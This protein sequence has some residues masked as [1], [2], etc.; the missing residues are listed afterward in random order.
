[1]AKRGKR[2][3]KKGQPFDFNATEPNNNVNE[4][5]QKIDGAAAQ[6]ATAEDGENKVLHYHSFDRDSLVY[7]GVPVASHP[8]QANTTVDNENNSTDTESKETAPGDP[9]TEPPKDESTPIDAS[10]IPEQAAGHIETVPDEQPS[11][12]PVTATDSPSSEDGTASE[13]T[14][15]T[16]PT[17]E[18][19][20]V[21]AVEGQIAENDIKDLSK[22]P[23]ET[24]DG[25]NPICPE[26]SDNLETVESSGTEPSSNDG[27]EV[28]EPEVPTKAANEEEQRE[29]ESTFPDVDPAAEIDQVE[30]EKEAEKNEAVIDDFDFEASHGNV[31]EAPDLE[32][33]KLTY[34][35]DEAVSE[36]AA[37]ESL[38]PADNEHDVTEE[39]QADS[40]SD[41]NCTTAKTAVDDDPKE[42]SGIDDTLDDWTEWEDKPAEGLKE[43]PALGENASDTKDDTEESSSREA[44]EEAVVGAE[45]GKVVAEDDVQEIDLAGKAEENTMETPTE[46]KELNIDVEK[47]GSDE[48]E[49]TVVEPPPEDLTAAQPG[50][51]IDDD[52][53]GE[54]KQEPE[55]VSE[56][57]IE[58][59]PAEVVLE[60]E[61]NET[62]T[63]ATV[64]TETPLEKCQPEE[65]LLEPPTKEASVEG[66]VTEKIPAEETLVQEAPV[67]EGAVEEASVEETPVKEAPVEEASV[68]EAPVEETSVKESVVEE[69]SVKESVVE[70][71]PVKET[72]VKEASVGKTPVEKTPVEEN[73]VEEISVKDAAVEEASVKEAS[74]E[75]A[76]VKET[77]VK[78]TPVEEA[79]VEEASVKETPVKEAP[80]EETS[81]KEASVEEASVKETSVKETSV[82]EASV[83]ETSVEEIS[84]KESAV[85]ET[86]VKETPVK[87]ASVKETSVKK[88]SVKETSVKESAVE[89]ASVEE[90]VV[91]E[92][93]VK[94][95]PV[96]EAPVEEA[97]VKEA[98]VKE[99]S[100]EEGAVEEVPVKDAA[101]E[102]VLVPADTATPKLA[103]DKTIAVASPNVESVRSHRRELPEDTR[104][105]RHKQ[106]ERHDNATSFEHPPGFQ[107]SRG[108]KEEYRNVGPNNLTAN[109]LRKAAKMYADQEQEEKRRR[110]RHR[111]EERAPTKYHEVRRESASRSRG[112]SSQNSLSSLAAKPVALLKLLANGESNTSGP[113]LRVN[114]SSSGPSKSPARH[115][116][117]SNRSHSHSHGHH[118]HRRHH[119]DR[120]PGVGNERRRRRELLGEV[121]RTHR[122]HREHKEHHKSRRDSDAQPRSARRDS[123]THHEDRERRG[124]RRHSRR[125]VEDEAPTG[126]RLRDRIKE[127]LRG[128]IPAAA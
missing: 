94:E 99:A 54:E 91:E 21:L 111:E 112:S 24:V 11:K 37:G 76:S 102:E 42:M 5:S 28:Q 40:E 45:S 122:E 36:S 96:K 126:M 41:P 8:P 68:E 15:D 78:E 26:A 10:D 43:L 60:K 100:V 117:S 83:E 23:D 90:N 95:A 79:S 73:V 67:E 2:K 116:D 125:Y 53:L 65:S 39:P 74:V 66:A 9:P 48:P 119:R 88:T 77:S 32:D 87:E 80:V 1:M 84:V 58:D 120:S 92:A 13:N 118:R 89:E 34:T 29:D 81:V 128:I 27:E 57:I 63:E 69:A 97:P 108:E 30:A 19:I 55:A 85:E 4:E 110:R 49:V 103:T 109:R 82:K 104:R 44:V 6:A 86:S 59:T 72:L 75:E 33:H 71:T 93:S 64:S 18:H 14:A 7:L 31:P 46:T 106:R 12:A 3:S 22:A 17:E 35:L 56:V 105:R 50:R 101:V 127:S 20:D 61:T 124:E 121:P 123:Y 38:S 107:Q 52:T 70:E 47:A 115:S 25:S 62:V 51:D 16:S 98:P 114:G 113:I